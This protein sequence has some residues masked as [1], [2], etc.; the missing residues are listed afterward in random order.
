MRRGFP[1]DR[2]GTREH[3][4]RSGNAFVQ[5]YNAALRHATVGDL[6]RTLDALPHDLHGFA[7]EGAS[8]ALGIFDVLTPWKHTRWTSLL[9]HAPQHVFLCFVGIGWSLARLRMRKIPRFVRHT[10]PL[11]AP[12]AADGFGFHEAFFKPD[13]IVRAAAL[14]PLAG[15]DAHGFD[16]GVGRAL[17]FVDGGNPERIAATIAAFAQQRQSDLWSGAGLALAY[18]GGVDE[19]KAAELLER[20]GQYRPNVAQ[21]IAFSAKARELA[22]NITAATELACSLAWSRNAREIAAL[23]DHALIKTEGTP[24]NVRYETWRHTVSGLL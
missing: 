8:M 13:R 17:W 7:Y 3:L 11:L 20:S 2:N 4:E 5:G 15:L 12:L 14:S 23:V 16:Q 22:G 24:A 6:G 21:G 19:R 18:A 1:D 10:N 9:E